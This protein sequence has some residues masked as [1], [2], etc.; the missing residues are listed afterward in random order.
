MMAE[1]FWVQVARSLA[2]KF[3]MERIHLRVKILFFRT[4]LN[5]KMYQF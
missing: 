1:L 3:E 2:N 4:N 5:H